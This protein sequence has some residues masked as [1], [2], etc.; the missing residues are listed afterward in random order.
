MAG[1]AKIDDDRWAKVQESLDLLFAQVESIDSTQQQMV[2]QLNLTTK[3]VQQ[4]TNDQLLLAKQMQYPSP[5]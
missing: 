3:M 2:A 1:N 5:S 4:T